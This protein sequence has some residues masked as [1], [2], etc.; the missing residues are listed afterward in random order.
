MQDGKKP[1][2]PG[3]FEP[4]IVLPK[5][6]LSDGEKRLDHGVRELARKNRPCI[7]VRCPDDR[8]ALSCQRCALSVKEAGA[9]LLDP[10]GGAPE[11]LERF[12]IGAGAMHVD[13]EKE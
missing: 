5:N 13:A 7:L 8:A 9:H 11:S 3:E 10:R 12:S 4:R 1:L 2:V 6:L